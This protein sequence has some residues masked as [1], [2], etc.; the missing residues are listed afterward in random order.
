VSRRTS[1]KFIAN[2]CK[3]RKVVTVT[4]NITGMMVRKEVR[5]SEAEKLTFIEELFPEVHNRTTAWKIWQ[6]ERNSN[7]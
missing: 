7:S 5:Q 3:Q 4:K 6:C 1:I 2:I